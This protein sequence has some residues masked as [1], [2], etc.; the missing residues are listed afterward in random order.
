MTKL[1]LLRFLI[2]ILLIP[3]AKAQKV[4]YKDLYG[5][6]STKQYEA[7]EPFLKRYI[8][9][10]TDNPNAYLYMGIVFQEKSMKDDFLR[11]TSRM[12]SSIDSAVIFYDKA[13]KTITEK[14][15]K[16]NSEYYQAYN[17]RDL[18]TGEFGVKL[19][20]IQFDLEK[21]MEGLRERKDRVKMAKHYF[22]LSDSLYKKASAMYKTLQTQY[23]GTKEF[24]LRADEETIRK[25]GSLSN[26]FDSCMKAFDQYKSSLA[27]V[28]KTG[29]NQVLTPQEISD[30]K[31]DG[32]TDAD[33]YKDNIAAWDYTKFA[34]R[35]KQAIETD[36]LPTRK[37]LITYDV[38]IN[39]LR[40]K[41]SGNIV[42]VKND[43]TGLVDKLLLDQLK[44]YDKEPLPME[45]FSL[46][47]ADLEYRSTV[48][49][50][51]QRPDSL[52]MHVK[53]S[54]IKKEIDALHKLDTIASKLAGEDLESRALDYEYFIKNTYGTVA[55]LKSFVS[56]SKQFA[57]R[58]LRF[59]DAKF[60]H[61]KESLRWIVNGTDSIPLFI[62]NVNSKF[63]PLEVIE[64]KYTAG[65]HYADS[66]SPS[67]Y[68]Y[69]ISPARTPEVKVTF[70]VDKSSFKR[71]RLS[72]LKSLTFSDAAGQLYFVLI[73]NDQINKD[74]KIQ[75][76]LAKIYKSDGLAWSLNYPLDFIPK[77][78]NFKADSGELTIKGEGDL[79]STIDKSGKVV[80]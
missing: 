22:A 18:R 20:D 59:K 72:T 13:Y 16:K 12:I 39:K 77:E 61:A 38:E 41:L 53:L 75:A 42:S 23:P 46:K 26:K 9:E 1:G 64:E 35:S 79:Q 65:I 74:M 70:A 14:E 8:R 57:A 47:I 24:Y 2:L 80:N 76:T 54:L 78:I 36:I 69:T 6:L 63:K 55:V 33:F 19:S 25:L 21:R 10:T 11:N 60:A 49:E 40:E 43:L 73:Y 29:Y 15:V 68:L 30:F 31:K 56:T 71:S 66:L 27:V 62:Q 51:K 4:K 44:K 5:L 28:G 7:A 48:I 52:D 50:N 34:A 17:R 58:E 45:L 67:G 37:H 32:A 3:T